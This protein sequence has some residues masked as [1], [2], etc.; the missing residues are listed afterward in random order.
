[1]KLFVFGCSNSAQYHTET[2]E[3]RQYRDFRKGEFPP[4]W[5]ELLSNKLKCELYNH[6][7]PGSGNDS[8]RMEFVKNVR[9]INENDIVIIGWTFIER[10]MWVNRITNEWDHY[11][12]MHTDKMDITINTH[13]EIIFHRAHN[14][15]N[16][17]NVKHIYEW[18]DMINY[19]AMKVNFKIYYWDCDGRILTPY[20]MY[21]GNNPIILNENRLRF[22]DKLLVREEDLQGTIFD[23]VRIN[24]GKKIIEETN[25]LVND[26]HWGQSGH[27]VLAES[28]FNRITKDIKL[29]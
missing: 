14:P 9:D 11:Q 21:I 25:G 28:F 12:H 22:S 23:Y 18:M 24:N 3:Y 2:L 27:E 19:I 15:S 5:S 20:Y 4:T 1:M 10:Y 8:I 16:Y 29:I 13:Q 17:L 6:A 7:I 26:H